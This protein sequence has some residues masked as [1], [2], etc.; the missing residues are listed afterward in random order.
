[1]PIRVENFKKIDYFK[2]CED[3]KE[4]SYAVGGNINCYISLE[5][6]VSLDIK[7]KNT[8]ILCP[9]RYISRNVSS[10]YSHTYVTY[11]VIFAMA[12]L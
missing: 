3:V 5:N 8:C 2:C 12:F 11:V 10:T 4:L 1:M 9:N 7:V 6:N